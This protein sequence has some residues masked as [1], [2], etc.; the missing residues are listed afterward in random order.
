[1][2]VFTQIYNNQKEN[3]IFENDLFF[4]ILDQAPVNPGHAL[5]IPKREIVGILELYDEEWS[6]LYP[7]LKKVFKQIQKLALV[8]IYNSYLN[9]PI[10]EKA[11]RFILQSLKILEEN[12]EIKDFNF[13]VNNGELAG[14]TVDHLHFHVIPRFQGDVE[15]PLGGVRYVVPIRA[16]YK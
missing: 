12:N 2:S 7:T 14:R 9:N 15:N 11:K 16:N 1:M 3:I 5:I 8:N 10:S 13:G 6:N 4:S